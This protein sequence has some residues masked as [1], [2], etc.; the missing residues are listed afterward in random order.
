MYP[1]AYWTWWWPL[2]RPK[3]VVQLTSFITDQLVVFWLP[4]TAPFMLHTQRGCLN[5]SLYRQLSVDNHCILYR[6]YFIS[7]CLCAEACKITF[8]STS[9]HINSSTSH[10]NWN[11]IH[12]ILLCIAQSCKG[13]E[14]SDTQ[15]TRN[16][17]V[18]WY[19]N[20]ISSTY[21]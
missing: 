1:I 6:N 12:T 19:Y 5:S 3:H 9:P 4:Y 18:Q 16:A 20:F 10:N 14:I 7:Y 15:L 2:S 11:G 17:D 13:N 8:N 21:H